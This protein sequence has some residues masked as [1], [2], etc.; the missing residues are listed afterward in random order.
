[1][2]LNLIG[3]TMFLVSCL[4]AATM[5]RAGDYTGRGYYGYGPVDAYGAPAV[6]PVPRRYPPVRYYSGPAPAY[7]QPPVY[8]APPAPGYFGGIDVDAPSSY[9]PARRN[10]LSSGRRIR[11]FFRQFDSNG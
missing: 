9:D 3:P 5:A 2:R 8:Y 1:M 4:S 11:Q 6:R 7:G 10:D